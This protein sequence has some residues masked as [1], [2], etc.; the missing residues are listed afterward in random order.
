MITRMEEILIQQK[1]AVMA[2][3]SNEYSWEIR[4]S[5]KV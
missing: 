1:N 3:E 2:M 4:N 5:R